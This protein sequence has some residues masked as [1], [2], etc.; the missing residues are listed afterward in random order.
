[1]S[2]LNAISQDS[3]RDSIQTYLNNYVA[4][5]D[6]VTG[7]DKRLFRFYPVNE[8]FRISAKFEQV[9]DGKWF[10][11]ETSGNIKKIFRV[12]GIAHFTINDT[13][14][15]LPIY[16]SQDLMNI[17]GYKR[18]LFVPFT[19][20]SS[21]EETYAAGRYLDVTID[22]IHNGTILLDFNKA[23]NPYCVYV[24][25]KYNCPIPPPESRLPVM[26]TAGEKNF[27]KAH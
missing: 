2:F 10:N 7:D 12:Y 5:H 8:K 4:E 26:I 13:A 23:Y 11:M 22:D 20:L 1:M 17:D 19:D 18:H 15:K 24:S 16:Q 6:V 25:G 9:S 14:V 21:G 27:A 3:Y